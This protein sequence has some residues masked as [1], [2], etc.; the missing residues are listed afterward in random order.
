MDDLRPINW[1][2]YLR[3][4]SDDDL[5][6]LAA[7]L[8]AEFLK[9]SEFTDI[10][11]RV[12]AQAADTWRGRARAFVAN[13]GRPV[14]QNYAHRKRRYVERMAALEDAEIRGALPDTVA[15]EELQVLSPLLPPPR[16]A[17]ELFGMLVRLRSGSG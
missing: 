12:Y 15:P 5:R 14:A 13:C 1:V 11:D 6:E 4:L 10:V 8:A 7:W 9:V 3:G 16:T 2:E 17:E